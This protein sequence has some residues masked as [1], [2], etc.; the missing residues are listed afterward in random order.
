[1]FAS[2]LAGCLMLAGCIGTDFL[3]ETVEFV[4]PHIVLTPLEEAIE[5]GGS[6]SYSATYFDSTDMAVAVGF[7]WTSSD[8]AVATVSADG[9]AQST[10]VGQARIRAVAAGIESPPALLTVVADPNAVA[11]VAVT[12]GDTSVTEGFSFQFAAEVFNGN[13]EVLADQ[14]VTWQVDDASLAT[15]DATGLVQ[16]LQSGDVRVTASADGIDSLPVLLQ[17]LTQQRT[18]SFVP[19]PGTSYTVEGGA[20]LE[21]VEADRLEL[22]FDEEFRS[23][24]GPD[25]FVYLSTASQVNASAVQLGRLQSTRGEQTYSIPPGVQINDFDYVIIHCLPFNVSFGH[26]QLD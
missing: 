26:A 20:V 12:P 10:G 25:L 22:R 23:S 4:D 7:T 14:M 24:N 3:E 16:T 11:R 8:E 21:Q 1:M 19:A 18:G 17:I 15:V 2:V 5:L 6:V 13:N 9:V